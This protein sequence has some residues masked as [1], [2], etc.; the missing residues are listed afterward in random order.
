MI[1][2]W[3]LGVW[4]GFTGALTEAWDWLK[5]KATQIWEGIAGWITGVWDGF[6]SALTDAWDWLKTKATQIWDEITGAI[7]GVWDDMKTKA[8]QIWEDVKEAGQKFIDAIITPIKGAIEWI[9]D[10]VKWVVEKLTGVKDALGGVL[11][12]VGDAVGGAVS[13]VKGWFGL[14]SGGA[15]APNNPMPCVLGDNKKEYEV[16]SPVSLMEKTVMSAIQKMGGVGGS[17]GPVELTINLD[18]RTMARAIYEPL[19]TEGRRRGASI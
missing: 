11:G 10:K 15:V 9:V 8:T 17:Q 16:V 5:E 3:I 18:G 6:T 19:R 1:S 13:T 7:L 2:G 12:G 4:N 14:A